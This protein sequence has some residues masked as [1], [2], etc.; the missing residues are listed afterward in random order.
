MAKFRDRPRLA[1]GLYRA[2]LAVQSDLPFARRELAKARPR[3]A[4]DVAHLNSLILGTTGT[5]NASC[6]HCPTGKASTA[7][8]P[9]GTMPM[10]MFKQIIDGVVAEGV[11]I[12][13][14]LA[15]GL[16]GD[17]LVDPLVLER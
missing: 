1:A 6:I 9:R 13:S 4:H 16:F 17:G 3:A 5:C 7:N 11:A 12:D 8:S 10:A 15:F 14:H 2:A